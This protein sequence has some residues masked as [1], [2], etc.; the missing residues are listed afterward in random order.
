MRLEVDCLVAGIAGSPTADD[1]DHAVGD[2]SVGYVDLWWDDGDLF[3]WQAYSAF[4]VVLVLVQTLYAAGEEYHDV[5][6]LGL[7]EVPNDFVNKNMVASHLEPGS[8]D[9]TIDDVVACLDMEIAADWKAM[10]LVADDRL[11]TAIDYAVVLV[12]KG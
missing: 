1:A 8:E 6:A 4:D 11:D 9:M 3:V 2:G 5:A 7:G 12:D 10:R